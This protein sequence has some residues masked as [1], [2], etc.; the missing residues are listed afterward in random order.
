[1]QLQHLHRGIDMVIA[2]TKVLQIVL[3]GLY[4]SALE[5]RITELYLIYIPVPQGGY[6]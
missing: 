4:S 1:M 6:L 5:Q 2:T 3:Y